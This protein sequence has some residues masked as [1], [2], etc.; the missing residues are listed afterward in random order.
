MKTRP[1][2][3]NHRICSQYSTLRAALLKAAQSELKANIR[4][5]TAKL[6]RHGMLA[7]SARSW[8][9][10]SCNPRE[11]SWFTLAPSHTEKTRT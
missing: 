10:H 6:I 4:D 11:R 3:P 5:K 7:E 2:N 8:A 9:D 1:I